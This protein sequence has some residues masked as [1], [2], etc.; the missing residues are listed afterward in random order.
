MLLSGP[1]SLSP[2]SRVISAKVF[3]GNLS[4]HTSKEEL[5]EVLSAAGE[6]V[7]AFLPVDRETGRPRGFAFVTF[8]T[9]EQASECVAK[10]NGQMVGGRSMNVNPAVE[11][12]RDGSGPR[13]G[14]FGGGGGGGGRG[15]Y[16]GGPGGGGGG[17]G[18]GGGGYGG[19]G[20]APSGGGYGGG[21]GGRGGFGGGGAPGGGGYGGG[22]GGGGGGYGGG[23]GGRGGFGGGPPGGGGSRLTERRSLSTNSAVAAL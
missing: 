13:P 11:R 7:D 10:F 9:P 18:G 20:G 19:G 23:G 16:G 3:V 4:Y 14:G 22:P 15:G 12:P 6:I 8:A 5:V 1:K 17:Y 21:G 2:W